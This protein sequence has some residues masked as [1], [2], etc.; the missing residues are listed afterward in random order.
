MSEDASRI[1]QHES[2]FE[3]GDIKWIEKI[4]EIYDPG[5]TLLHMS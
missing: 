3:I 4:D 1:V 5:T 2:K